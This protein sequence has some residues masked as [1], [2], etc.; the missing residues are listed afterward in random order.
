MGVLRQSALG[1]NLSDDSTVGGGLTARF[2]RAVVDT[3]GML[4]CN[5]VPVTLGRGFGYGS[6]LLRM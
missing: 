1:D 5:R 3:L 6:G 4:Q 2:S